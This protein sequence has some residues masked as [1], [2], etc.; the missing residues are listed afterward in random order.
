[1]KY[2]GKY[3]EYIVLSSLLKKDIEAYLAI[4]TNQDDYDITV[5]NKN[6]KILRIQVK[7]TELNNKSTNNSITG[8][9]KQY[10]FLVLVIVSNIDEIFIIPKNDVVNLQ[11]KN[12]QLGTTFKENKKSQVKNEIKKYKDKWELIENA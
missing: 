11:D 12:K 4:K 1:M 6:G 7:T 10:D 3:G 2:I 9:D 8:T 5:I